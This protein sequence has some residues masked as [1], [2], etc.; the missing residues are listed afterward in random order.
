MTD[1]SQDTLQDLAINLDKLQDQLE[2]AK[3]AAATIP[4]LTEHISE[5]KKEMR[6]RLDPPYPSEPP[7][8]DPAEDG[9]E[10][11]EE[12]I[13]QRFEAETQAV[14]AIIEDDNRDM[15]ADARVLAGA[16]ANFETPQ[17]D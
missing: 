12:G 14:R 7:S 17:T 9:E 4:G 2:R 3:D 15:A 16:Y 13:E 8:A 6:I 1:Y 11:T 10:L 5:I